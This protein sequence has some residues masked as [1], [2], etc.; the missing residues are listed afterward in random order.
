MAFKNGVNDIKLI[1][2]LGNTTNTKLKVFQ[3][4]SSK[5]AITFSLATTESFKNREGK[6]EERTQWHDIVCWGNQARFVEKNLKTGREV[7]VAGSLKY[8]KYKKNVN[9][10][11]IEIT[12]AEVEAKDVKF[13]DKIESTGSQPYTPPS[14]P[15]VKAPE[16]PQ[17]SAQQSTT[18]SNSKSDNSKSPSEAE[19]KAFPESL[20]KV[21]NESTDDLF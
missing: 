19:N 4:G 13:F 10:M 15:T 21:D 17:P 2:N 14:A 20:S 11:D 12:K 5:C 1:G 9:G 8:R 7:Y 3:Q 18:A 16:T 6:W